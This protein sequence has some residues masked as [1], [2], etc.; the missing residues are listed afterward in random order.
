MH[1]GVAK[2]SILEVRLINILVRNME[3]NRVKVVL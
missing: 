2:V 1:K 3:T